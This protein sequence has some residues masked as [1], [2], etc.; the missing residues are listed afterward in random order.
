VRTYDELMTDNASYIDHACTLTVSGWEIPAALTLP[1]ARADTVPVPSAILL[2]P[3]SLFSDV[4]GDYP[5]WD[6]FPHVYA[7]LAHQ[8]AAR[9]QAVYRFAKLG[10]GTGSIAVDADAAAKIRTWDGRLV[11]ATAAL[12]A[13][14]RE[15]AS[16]DLR[17]MRIIAAGHSEGSVVVS[18]LAV[19]ERGAELDGV[20]LLAGPSI[21]IL[22]IMREQIGVMTP[23][24]E[25]D[26]AIRRLDIAIECIRRGEPIPAE[27]A[28]GSPMGA[29]VL[30][31][32]P[33]EGRRYMRD[34]D[35]TDP[36]QLAASIR[37]R[38]LVVQG[39]NDASVPRHHGEALRD[40]L[41]SRPEGESLTDYLFV[42]GVTHMFKLV[43]PGVTGV[44]LFGYPG[45]TDVR[46]ADGIDRWIRG[47]QERRVNP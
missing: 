20:V 4:N 8:L 32:M 3:G 46:V 23:A 11:I 35:A 10:P 21:G 17:A 45:E 7:H 25:R 41:L 28:T 33:D 29:G 30:A 6:S 13:M 26:D 37:Q 18:R 14:R 38:T 19:S 40:T 42:P 24:D 12:D 5:T 39:G 22:G 34:V 2:V 16:R 1:I 15:L 43:P 44:E 27:L 36:T 31:A 47:T 9:G